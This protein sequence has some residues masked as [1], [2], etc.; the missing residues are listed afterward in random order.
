MTATSEIGGFKELK[1][2]NAADHA[3]GWVFLSV[4]SM[5]EFNA[6]NANPGKC[7]R[8]KVN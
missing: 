5:E 7:I 6:F 8:V 1:A 2:F 4:D 3:F